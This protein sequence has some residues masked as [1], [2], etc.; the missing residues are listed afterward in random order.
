MS[1]E[2]DIDAIYKQRWDKLRTGEYELA[3]A[4]KDEDPAAVYMYNEYIRFNLIALGK[5]NSQYT[6]HE[7]IAWHACVQNTAK[8]VSS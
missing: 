1:Y 2:Y 6:K 4:G 5:D 8:N 3:Q 7:W